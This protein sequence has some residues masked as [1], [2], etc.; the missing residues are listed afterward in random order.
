MSTVEAHLVLTRGL[1]DIL[2]SLITLQALIE[3]AL[4]PWRGMSAELHVGLPQT[5][6]STALPSL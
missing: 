5:G 4:S 3:S 6:N 1:R 2:S